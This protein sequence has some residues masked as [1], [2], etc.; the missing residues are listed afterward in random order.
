MTFIRLIG[1]LYGPAGAGGS[2]PL[3]AD[4]GDQKVPAMEKKRICFVVISLLFTALG[5]RFAA[6]AQTPA[7][8]FAL[9]KQDF[10]LDGKPFQIVSGELHPARIPR[11]YWLHRIR[12]V[13]AMGCNTVAAYLF[14]NYHEGEPGQFDFRTENRDIAEFFRLVQKEGMWA[15]VRPGPYVCAEW[16]FGGLPPYL[17]RIPDIRVRCLDPRY[18]EAAE[19]YLARLAAILRPLQI[20][21]G[22][23]ILLLQVENEYG[24]YGNDT[25]YLLALRDIWR[26]N[27]IDIPFFTGDGATPHMLEAGSI[28]GAA[29]GL[30]PGT[31][32]KDFEEARRRNPA[33]PVFSSETYPGWLTHWGEPWARVEPAR[34]AQEVEFLLSTGRSLN[35]YVAHGG[36]NFG[37]M[38]GAN[39]GNKGYEPDVTSYDYDAPIDEQGRPTAKFF[40][41]RE[42]IGKFTGPPPAL[43]DPVPA[44]AVPE[45]RMEIKSS[46]WDNLPSAI[47][48]VQPG[49]MESYGQDYGFLIYQ[50]RLIGHHSGKLAV[51]GL[52]DFATV[53]VDG[54]FI[55]TLDR[56]EAVQQ[57]ELPKTESS[58]PVLT[59]LVEAMG[60]INFGPHLLD[61]KGIT[62]LVT[63]NNMTLMNWEV[64]LL[65]MDAAWLE[66]LKP[67]ASRPARPGI[68]FRGSFTTDSSADTFLDLSPYRKGIV[69]VN[70][71]NL[72]RYWEIGP[73]KRLYCPA[74]WLRKGPNEV[75][76][77]DLLQTESRPI[78]GHPTLQ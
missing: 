56:R 28:D 49:P 14:W 57:I 12:M 75:L 66:R 52:H 60:R 70:G 73:Q 8:A 64:F 5:E 4:R 41:L 36:T 21:R 1:K 26:K 59:L 53:F 38:A 27:G 72:G 19:R 39:S 31:R 67:P 58:R 9:G 2:V 35:L 17:L 76:I 74:P 7:H 13:K 18:M 40:T 78:A 44:M 46:V 68:F 42:R 54:R 24:S 65:P 61:R 16:D 6:G 43:P 15:I 11:E 55:G 77:F 37:Y 34:I 3:H 10:L 23:P 45:I 50:T 32:E 71:H 48:S 63:L 47:P 20:T 33:V 62:G 69:W 51:D 29:I 22:G 30:D 25:S